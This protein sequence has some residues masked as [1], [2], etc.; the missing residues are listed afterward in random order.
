MVACTDV[1]IQ[2]EFKLLIKVACMPLQSEF[3]YALNNILNIIMN[4]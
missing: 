1:H 2:S 3:K 4:L